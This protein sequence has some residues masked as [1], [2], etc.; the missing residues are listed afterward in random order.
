MGSRPR[1]PGA[2]AGRIGRDGLLKH[3]QIASAERSRRPFRLL[4]E[5]PDGAQRI[6]HADVVIDATGT[7]ANPNRLGDGASKPS[8]NAR[9]SRAS[10]RF[11]QPLHA[12]AGR[13]VLLTGSGH[14]AQTAARDLAPL[15]PGFFILGAKSYGRNSNFLLRIGWQQVDDV[16]EKLM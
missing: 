8:A 9:S 16:F 3:E 10:P 11:L 6:E 12:L 5:G 2:T 4:V 14:S 15:E 1:S 13:T 7:Y